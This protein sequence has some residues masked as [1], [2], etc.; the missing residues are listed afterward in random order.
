MSNILSLRFFKNFSLYETMIKIFTNFVLCE[1]MVIFLE[2]LMFAMHFI[3]SLFCFLYFSQ[4]VWNIFS[5][6]QKDLHST[7]II[8]YTFYIAFKILYTLHFSFD[9]FTA[10]KYLWYFKLIFHTIRIA[11]MQIIKR[12]V[13]NICKW[14]F[15]SYFYY[16]FSY[17]YVFNSGYSWSS[18][19]V[20]PKLLLS[21]P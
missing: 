6:V 17:T 11:L 18:F 20:F 3:C 9:L 8:C 5:T 4:K 21:L 16:L 15:Y 7:E 13:I 14:I 2:F 10:S 1:T 19:F 12:N